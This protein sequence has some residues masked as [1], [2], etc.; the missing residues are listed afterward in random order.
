MRR[1]VTFHRCL[2]TL[3]L[4]CVQL[5]MP[6]SAT[7]AMFRGG[8]GLHDVCTVAASPAPAESDT[9][10]GASPLAAHAQ[11]CALCSPLTGLPPP[12]HAHPLPEAAPHALL[13]LGDAPHPRAAFAAAVPARG[14]PLAD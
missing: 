1:F 5:A 7:A 9:S 14:P 8:I 13:R 10:P 12:F 2:L 3:V 11:H 4:V 6:V